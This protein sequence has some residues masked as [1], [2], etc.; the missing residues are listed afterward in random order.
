[1]ITL[2]MFLR[3][4]NIIMK[5]IWS[6]LL[7]YS[8]STNFLVVVFDVLVANLKRF[9]HIFEISWCVFSN[10][11]VALSKLFGVIFERFGRKKAT[12]PP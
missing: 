2:C 8:H 4:A 6:I 11:L 5:T 12:T 3:L 9:G 10:I 1:M 7:F